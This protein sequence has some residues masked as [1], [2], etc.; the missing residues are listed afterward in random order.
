MAVRNIILSLLAT[1]LFAGPAASADF[2]PWSENVFAYI[3]QEFGDEAEKRMRFVEKFILD[4]QNIPDMEKVVQTN[5]VSNHLPWIAD[6][7]HWKTSD[8][9]ATPLETITTFGGDCEDIA[10]VKWVIL[11]N[12]GLSAD[13]LALAY[14]KIKETGE[15]HM[16]LL[17]VA[18]PDAPAG[19]KEVYILDNYVDEV[20]LAEE[21]MDLLAVLAIG[22]EGRVVLF[23]DD[24]EK[25]SVK[26]SYEG[27]KIKQVEDL[28]ERVNENRA[29]FEEINEGRSLMP[30]A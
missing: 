28:I 4:N 29:K 17:Y 30:D 25:R 9:W 14:V 19:Q 27:R 15:D 13:N 3:K 18:K 7:N 26:A 23:N 2:Q 22:T 10:L 8:Y 1:F 6:E 24:G 20:K 11:R 12:L 5:Q 21:R 16:V